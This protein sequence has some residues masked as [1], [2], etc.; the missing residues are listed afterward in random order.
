MEVFI[1]EGEASFFCLDKEKFHAKCRVVRGIACK[2]Y[3]GQ[4]YEF[5]N[6]I[7]LHALGKVD[8]K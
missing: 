6:F 4:S 1:L 2:A 5:A 8:C 3:L 7:S